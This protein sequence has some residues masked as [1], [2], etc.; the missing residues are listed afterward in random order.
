MGYRAVGLDYAGLGDEGRAGEYFSM[1]FQ[2]REHASEREKSEISS[3]Y[4]RHV[5]GELDKAARTFKE[6]IESYPRAAKVEH[7]N[8]R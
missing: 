3:A 8:L 4:Y 6:E 5:T 2:L 7:A 1:A